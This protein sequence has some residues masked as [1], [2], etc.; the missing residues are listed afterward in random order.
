[1]TDKEDECELGYCPGKPFGD[2]DICRRQQTSYCVMGLKNLV[3]WENTV[4]FMRIEKIVKNEN[5]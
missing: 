4:L 2:E 5:N 1:M 3:V